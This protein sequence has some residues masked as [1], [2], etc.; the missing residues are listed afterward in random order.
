MAKG[1]LILVTKY[2]AMYDQVYAALVTAYGSTMTS[3]RL[4]ETTKPKI[5]PTQWTNLGNDIKK[6]YRHQYGYTP[7]LPANVAA[8]N[9]ITWAQISIYENLAQSVYDSRDSV[10]Q[11]G[12]SGIYTQQYTS[13]TLAT[14]YFEP[15]WNNLAT[16]YWVIQWA[17]LADRQY[18]YNLG[19]KLVITCQMLGSVESPALGWMNVISQI[20]GFSYAKGDGAPTT[21]KSGSVIYDSTTKYTSNYGRANCYGRLPYGQEIGIS[22]NDAK[23]GNPDEAVGNRTQVNLVV[24]HSTG[25]ITAPLPSVT[26]T[27]FSTSSN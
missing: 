6:A 9:Q 18:F 21:T 26:Q 4:D 2:N 22:L 27:N 16:G 20:S 23:A 24:Y 15:G 7:N 25:E 11:G 1:D 12:T 19:G 14:S 17:N 5:T 8:S 13:Y 10:Y 3:S